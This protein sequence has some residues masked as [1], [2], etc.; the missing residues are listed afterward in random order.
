VGCLLHPRIDAALPLDAHLG[1]VGTGTG[2]WLLEVAA[3]DANAS[4]RRYT[5][6]DISLAQFP[7]QH[8]DH[9]LFEINNILEPVPEKWKA[10]FDYLH[11]RPLICDFSR[12]DWQTAVSNLRQLLKPGDGCSG[13]REISP[14]CKSCRTCPVR[15][16]RT[17]S[18]LSEMVFI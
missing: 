15:A 4:S 10:Q 3:K 1:E 18:S 17:A 11:L 14:A 6:L 7:K 2:I 16:R 5:G 8:P 13:K 12:E 9:V